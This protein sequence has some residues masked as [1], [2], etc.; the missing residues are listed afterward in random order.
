M[1]RWVLKLLSLAALLASGAAHADDP[2][3]I[4]LG[5]SLSSGYGLNGAA[6]WVTLLDRRLSDEGYEYDVVNAS[7][8]G[9]TSAGGLSRL[10][11]LLEVH[12]PELVV[13]EMGGNDG[14][15]GQPVGNLRTNLEKM[16]ELV[17]ASGAA[18]LL[19]GIQIP[20]NYGPLYTSQFAD[21]YPLLAEQHEIPLVEF[22][23]DGVALN[24]HLMQ[25]D[26]I[27]PNADGQPLML[28]N[29]WRVLSGLLRADI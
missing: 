26:R 12:E 11:R 22:L 15:R 27:H 4:V 19:T 28:D 29:V 24:D 8:A 9:D 18:V 1:R 21:L 16:I 5:D 3:I 14:L 7:I 25:S 10:P 20:P 6:S 17:K 13:I 2:A 23:M